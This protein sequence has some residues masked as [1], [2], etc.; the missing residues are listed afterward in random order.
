MS[1]EEERKQPA[2]PGKDE[3]D[4]SP[5]V[6]GEPAGAKKEEEACEQKAKKGREGKEG[7]RKQDANKGTGEH[8][9]NSCRSGHSMQKWDDNE[10]RIQQTGEAE[11][12]EEGHG[13]EW[14]CMMKGIDTMEVITKGIIN[15]IQTY[16]LFCEKLSDDIAGQRLRVNQ[17]TQ[18]I[19]V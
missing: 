7:E 5:E 9:S 11:I 6:D 10:A 1:H 18:R 19:R 12:D 3:R 8:R 2:R 13:E 4:T 17:E 15:E 14:E 16:A